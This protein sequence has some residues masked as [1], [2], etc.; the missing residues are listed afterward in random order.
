[1]NARLRIY[2]QNCLEHVERMEE[3]W[4]KKQ[5]PGVAQKERESLVVHVEG[6]TD[7]IWNKPS[8]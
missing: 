3:G 1:M 6:G 4:A 5:D 8:A 7:R 2:R